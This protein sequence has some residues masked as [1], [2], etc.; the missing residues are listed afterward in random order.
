MDEANSFYQ[1]PP[2]IDYDSFDEDFKIELFDT[3]LPENEN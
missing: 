3:G 1:K 2:E